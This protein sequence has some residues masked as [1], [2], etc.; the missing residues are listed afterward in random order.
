MA[1]IDAGNLYSLLNGQI[2]RYDGF[3]DRHMI[4]CNQQYVCVRERETER[5]GKGWGE[6][7]V[8]KSDR[9]KR[10]PGQMP[11]RSQSDRKVTDSAFEIVLYASRKVK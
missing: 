8:T 10:S 1:E 4:Y 7:K 2:Y 9:S 11:E 5:E 3:T 6:K